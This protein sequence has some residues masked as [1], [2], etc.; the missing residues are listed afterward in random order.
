[1]THQQK[2]AAGAACIAAGSWILYQA[3]EGSGRKRPFWT[4]ILPGA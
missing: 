4:K 3:Y 2:V 1:V